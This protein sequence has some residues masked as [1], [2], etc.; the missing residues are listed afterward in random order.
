M[1]CYLKVIK[2][3]MRIL[4]NFRSDGTYNLII[5]GVSINVPGSGTDSTVYRWSEVD[6]SSLQLP[7]TVTSLKYYISQTSVR[8]FINAKIYWSMH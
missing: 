6:L 7:I 8:H 1:M 2:N 3:N 4:H 5:N